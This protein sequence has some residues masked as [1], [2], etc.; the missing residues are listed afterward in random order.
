MESTYSITREGE[1]MENT[2]KKYSYLTN[3]E[4]NRTLLQR[5]DKCD[6]YDYIAAVAC[7]VIGGMI[8]IFLVGAPKDSAL[9]EWTDQQADR[10]VMVFARKLGWNPKEKNLNN[11][12]SAIGFLEGRFKVNYDQ[13]KPGDVNDLFNIAPGTHHMMSL[14]HSPDLVGLF[15]RF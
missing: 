1:I 10:T 11:V 2:E 4:E 14:A 13:R 9:V 7:G 6:K 8:D 5:E 15:F 3:C 12:N